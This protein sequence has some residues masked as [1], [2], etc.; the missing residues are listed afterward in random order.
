MPMMG[1]TATGYPEAE[2][3]GRLFRSPYGHRAFEVDDRD[4]SWIPAPAGSTAKNMLDHIWENRVSKL[5]V[6]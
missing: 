5:I 4:M 1:E 3:E 2:R 6:S